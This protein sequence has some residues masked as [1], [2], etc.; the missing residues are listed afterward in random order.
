VGVWFGSGNQVVMSDECE[1]IVLIRR[2][3]GVPDN[4]SIV[5]VAD[6]SDHWAFDVNG[7]FIARKR[8][9]SDEDAAA[10]VKREAALLAF[11]SRVSPISVPEVVALEPEAGLI[12]FRRL[13]GISLF[14]RPPF[15]PRAFAD[16]LADF[17]AAMQSA[18]AAV[19][20]HLVERDEYPIN[21]YVA[22]AVGQMHRVATYL[23]SAQRW[24]VEQF[25]ASP[26]P[27]ESAIRTLCHN[28]LGAEHVLASDDGSKLTGIID[29]SDAAI[30]DPAKDLGRLLRDFGSG[31]AE[32]VLRRI[33]GAEGMFM[34][35]EFY[36]RCALI[37]DLA[38]GIEASRPEYVEHALARLDETFS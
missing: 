6:G 15:D 23:T 7:V 36:A 17:V 11:V 18:P 19:V 12:I 2:L 10:A 3:L 26:A 30:T 13:P 1:C 28:D 33:G 32:A 14:D 38:Y 16:V 34:R 37:E 21:A 22:E 8:K 9:R 27:P 4:R 5:L 29:W 31:V 20:T 24:R 35:A 25:L